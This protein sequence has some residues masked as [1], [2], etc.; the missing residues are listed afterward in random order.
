MT[1]TIL[2]HYP[3]SPFAEKVR[4]MLGFKRVDWRSVHIPVIMPKP[5]LMALTGGYRR[6]PV[7][8][9]GADVYCDTA[10]IARVLEE[11]QPAPTLYPAGAPLAP[12]FAHWAD[13]ALFWVA[14]PYAMQPAGAAALFPGATPEMLKAF[15]LDRAPFAAGMKRQTAVDAAAAL[16]HHLCALDA[17]LADGRPFLFGAEASIADFAVAH[18]L[19]FIRRAAPVAGI[20]QP[21][22]GLADWLDG[23]LAIGHGSSRPMDAAEALQV[24]ATAGARVATAVQPGLGFDAGQRVSVAATDY[25][26][27]AVAGELVGLTPTR[28]TIGRDDERAGRVHVHFPRIAFQILKEKS[29]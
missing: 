14:V 15:A 22:A 26:T 28:V 11:L 16:Q 4:L 17:Q 1:E 21:H 19:W 8:Q 9:I 3:G 20:L 18:P 24:A 7:L 6:T 25:G 29:A 23:M 27:D 13:S 5:E 12:L 10:L 2:H